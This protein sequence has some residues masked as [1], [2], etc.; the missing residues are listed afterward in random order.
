LASA[1]ATFDTKFTTATSDITAYPALATST[2]FTQNLQKIDRLSAN[3][4][5]SQKCRNQ[6]TI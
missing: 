1:I 2:T 5:C 4:S 6:F 3:V